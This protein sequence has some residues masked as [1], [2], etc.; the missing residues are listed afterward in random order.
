[1]GCIK[2]V[3]QTVEDP[4][5][6]IL[7]AKV[8]TPARFLSFCFLFLGVVVFRRALET[9]VSPVSLAGTSHA[10]VME[11]RSHVD[12]VAVGRRLHVDDFKFFVQDGS[13]GEALRYT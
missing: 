2:S 10:V 5:A 12:A 4:M 7:T 13:A 6:I 9:P 8:E 1:M 11:R 3:T